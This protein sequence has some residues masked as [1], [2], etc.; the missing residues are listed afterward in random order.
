MRA[1]ALFDNEEVGSDSAYGEPCRLKFDVCLAAQERMAQTLGGGQ[2][3][4]AHAKRPA[5]PR[6][7]RCASA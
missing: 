3:P 1:V 6:Q 5:L 7:L 4:P 2:P